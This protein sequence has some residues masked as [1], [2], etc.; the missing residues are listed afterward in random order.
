MEEYLYFYRRANEEIMKNIAIL[1]PKSSVIQ[2]IADPQYMFSA[3]NQFFIQAGQSAPFNVALIGEEK[4]IDLNDGMY[5]IHTDYLLSDD[6]V[7][8]LIIVPALFGDMENA[9]QQNESMKKWIQEKY[10]EGSEVAS[11]CVGAFLLASTGLLKDKKCSTHWGFKDEF[12]C[13]FPEVE[14][15]EGE[16]VT[17]DSGIY[18]SG[19]AHSYWNLLLHI[20]EKKTN[21]ETAILTAKY[22][23]IDIDRSSQA[24]FTIFKGQKKHEDIDVLKVQA[25]I[26]GNYSEKITIDFL[27][28]HFGVGRRSLERRF[29]LATNNSI[30]EYIQRSKIEYAKR[31]FES[32]YAHVNDVMFEVG[33]SDAKAFR[34]L[35]KKVNGVD[36]YRL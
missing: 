9:I 26:E 20:L 10:A 12:M 1:V 25:Y 17:E 28:E 36:T 23:A 8:E 18:S 30:L 35:F 13:M 34:Q 11:L 22:F 24:A 3:V 15:V 31:C 19:G 7:P 33:Y 29:K 4:I 27:A 2:A 5:S 32:S 14:L 16:I 6:F 21:R